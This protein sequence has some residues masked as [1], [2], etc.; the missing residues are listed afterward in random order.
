MESVGEVQEYFFDYFPVGEELFSLALPSTSGLTQEQALWTPYEEAI[1]ARTVDGL[2]AACLSL[3]G[4]GGGL[5]P[6]VRFSRSSALTALVGQ[7]LSARF[8][9]ER[10]LL[11]GQ[12]PG[13]S[14]RPSAPSTQ[15]TVLLLDRRDDPVTPLLNQWTYQAMLHELIGLDRN[16]ATIGSDECVFSSAQDPFFQ[17]NLSANFGDLGLSVKTLLEDFQRNTHSSHQK[18]ES[19]D[20]MQR[21][22]EEYPEFR[23]QSG[24]VSK[25]VAA[26]HALSTLV[27]RGNL[28]AVSSLEQE[29][30]CDESKQQEHYRRVMTVLGDNKQSS[31][32]KLRLALLYALRYGGSE[33]NQL[34]EGLVASGVDVA[35]ANLID[36]LLKYAGPFV[37]GHDLFKQGVFSLAKKAIERQFGGVS[38]VYTQHKSW[39]GGVAENALKGKLKDGAYPLIGAERLSP[40]SISGILLVFVVGGVTFEEARDIRQLNAVNSVKI[41]LGGTTVH[42]SKSFLAD[43][44]QVG[45]GRVWGEQ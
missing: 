27:E 39:L 35:Q 25:H 36:L 40:N 20:D 11:A 2:F 5:S 7:A 19:I 44:A 1:F 4:G 10:V 24:N 31:F 22:I 6:S 41:V 30:V 37:R 13:P 43:V 12:A 23:K 42:N 21:F 15:L 28:L 34:K 29:L 9:E 16:R 45:R 14:V 3:R 38:N 33:V 18:I 17:S 26:V 32:E 8:D